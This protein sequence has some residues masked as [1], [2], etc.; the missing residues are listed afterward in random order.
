MSEK[1]RRDLVLGTNRYWP[2]LLA[3]NKK[4]WDTNTKTLPRSYTLNIYCFGILACDGAACNRLIF[5]SQEAV[6]EGYHGR[7]G[8]LSP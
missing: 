5:G 1:G 3:V 2:E 4:S 6:R 8:P 7:I